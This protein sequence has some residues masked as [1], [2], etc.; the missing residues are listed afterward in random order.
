H[1]LTGRY[2]TRKNF[3]VSLN[4]ISLATRFLVSA[5]QHFR[6]NFL[7]HSNRKT[8]QSSWNCLNK[9]RIWSRQI[10]RVQ[11]VERAS[12]WKAGIF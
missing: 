12:L 6:L 1:T 10:F 9:N 2:A 11:S 4:L 3:W 7:N 5:N 8:C